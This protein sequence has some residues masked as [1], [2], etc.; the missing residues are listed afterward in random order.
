MTAHH[1]CHLQTRNPRQAE[2]R[3]LPQVTQPEQD[4]GPEPAAGRG[5]VVNRMPP[6][7][8]G[9]LA[10]AVQRPCQ[11]NSDFRERQGPALPE[12]SGNLP[13]AGRWSSVSSRCAPTSATSARDRD[14]NESLELPSSRLGPSRDVP[15]CVPAGVGSIFRLFSGEMKL[16]AKGKR[17]P[18]EAGS[19]GSVQGEDPAG[20]RRPL[21]AS[22]VCACGHTALHRA[23]CSPGAPSHA[24]PRRVSPAAR[25]GRPCL[26]EA[27]RLLRSRPP[28]PPH[29]CPVR[30]VAHHR[31]PGPQAW[32]PHGCPPGARVQ[33]PLSRAAGTPT[34]MPRPPCE[35]QGAGPQ[36]PRSISHMGC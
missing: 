32:R 29:S 16:A 28:S 6:G 19:P 1:S 34:L 3:R 17:R 31:R 9:R 15:L 8:S 10:S 4:P 23:S 11:E 24:E 12:G 25:V 26:P 13:K 33:Q 22:A 2:Q 35:T 27:P 14:T 20:C 18:P 30:R 21:L 36:G 7:Q 5:P